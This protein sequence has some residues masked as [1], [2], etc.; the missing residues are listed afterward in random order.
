VCCE[1]GLAVVDGDDPLQPKLLAMVPMNRPTSVAVQFR[2]A[3]VT[4]ADGLKVVDVTFPEKAAPVGAAFP[5]ADAR[6]VYVAREYAYVAAGA[7]GVVFVDVTVPTA[8]K[9]VVD[10]QTGETLAPYQAG[11]RLADVNMV[12]IGMVNDSVYAMVAD[13]QTGLHVLQVVTP[14]DGGRSAYG[15]SPSP[16]PRWIANYPAAG[17]RAIARGLDRDRAADE[18]GN[19]VSVFGRIGGRPFTLEEQRRFYLRPS[20]ELY[21]VS[22]D[23]PSGWAPQP[24]KQK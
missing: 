17:A 23:V 4:D 14:M 24:V 15:F 19:Q 5:I 18:S 11:G 22:D 2:Y 8:L 13:G 9:A 6:N 21:T 16:R 7:Q 12:R 3:F 20:G 1:L 10:P